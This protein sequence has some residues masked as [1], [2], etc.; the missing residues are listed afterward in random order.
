MHAESKQ[1]SYETE[2]TGIRTSERHCSWRDVYALMNVDPSI[3]PPSPDGKRS[4]PAARRAGEGR[5]SGD[6]TGDTTSRDDHTVIA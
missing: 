2:C 3:D 1:D 5:N 4:R 6:E